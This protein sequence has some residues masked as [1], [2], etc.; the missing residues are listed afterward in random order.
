GPPYL[1]LTCALGRSFSGSALRRRARRSPD[2]RMSETRWATKS[3]AAATAG[4]A[5]TTAGA[6]AEP[7]GPPWRT[8]G[9]AADRPAAVQS[10]PGRT[11]HPPPR[12]GAAC[13]GQ[14]LVGKPRLTWLSDGSGQRV[15]TTLLRV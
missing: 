10:A 1:L 2:H 9:R 4:P 6:A 5:A 12:K 14:E 15:V 8:S 7:A 11:R 3:S 13:S